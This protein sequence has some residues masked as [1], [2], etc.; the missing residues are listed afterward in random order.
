MHDNSVA[1]NNTIVPFPTPDEAPAKPYPGW[2]SP[3]TEK[4]LRRSGLTGT[5]VVQMNVHDLYPAERKNIPY[6]DSAAVGYVIPYLD[7]KRDPIIDHNIEGG[8]DG[9]AFFR[10][11]FH[12]VARSE[13][14]PKYVQPTGSGVHLFLPCWIGDLLRN[15][16]ET[17]LIVEGEKKAAALAQAGYAA[18]GIGGV[19][20]F[21][22][23]MFRFR[24]EGT[25]KGGPGGLSQFKVKGGT[26]IAEVLSAPEFALLV[27][28]GRKVVLLFDSDLT[29]EESPTT[30]VKKSVQQS[31][32]RGAELLSALG[33]HVLQGFFPWPTRSGTKIGADDYLLMPGNDLNSIIARAKPILPPNMK[34][35]VRMRL[36]TKLSR[37][38]KDQLIATVIRDLDTKGT[39]YRDEVNPAMY[40][41]H[42]NA[43]H[44]LHVLNLQAPDINLRLGS[45]PRLLYKDYGLSTADTDE[46]KR[47]QPAFIENCPEVRAQ[48]LFH[49]QDDTLYIQTGDN[50]IFRI[51]RQ[52]IVPV[53]NGFGRVLFR[54][55]NVEPPNGLTPEHYQGQPRRVWRDVIA[56][57]SLD[58]QEVLTI[59]ETRALTEVLVYLVPWFWNWRGLELPIICSVGEH[60]S[61]KSY[62]WYVIQGVLMGK[63]LGIQ[64]IVGTPRDISE[65]RAIL[66]DSQGILPF[67]NFKPGTVRTWREQYEEEMSRTVTVKEQTYRPLYGDEIK[68]SSI[69]ALPA[70]SSIEPPFLSADLIER[71][72]TI[73]FKKI[74]FKEGNTPADWHH[75]VLDENPGRTAL[76]GDMMA[77]AREFLNVAYVRRDEQVPQRG[78]LAGFD[79]ALLY[80]AEALDSTGEL[81]TLMDGIID[82]LPAMIQASQVEND[83]A[84]QLLLAFSTEH[85]R[86]LRSDDPAVAAKAEE[87]FRLATVRDWYLRKTRQSA[88]IAYPFE[89]TSKLQGFIKRNK[90]TVRESTGLYRAEEDAKAGLYS[91]DPDV[92]DRRSQSPAAL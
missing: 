72:I 35:H 64:S 30:P 57:L 77:A 21:T 91:V 19:D 48:K 44:K 31:A 88:R 56:Q 80:M 78:R 14:V 82:K 3:E 25:V 76:L 73:P 24:K 71:S 52:G 89:T 26:S 32:F 70:I 62:F 13:G 65:L 79:R 43:T 36:D 75:K 87:R 2:L 1:H 42:E 49:M 39:R 59:E 51:D 37:S 34:E 29:E 12:D 69:K 92:I 85:L 6:G 67:D 33:A 17:L 5:T 22:H 63:S 55:G 20:S 4:D 28:E 68:T 74:D 54:S 23:G 38:A 90:A 7:F 83:A 60:G 40:Y 11:R 58:E 18:V 86:T 66:R 16:K 81:R 9:E 46:M 15:P 84:I 27:L 41:Y 47:F 45:L 53:Y 10:V 50:D 8:E 61:G